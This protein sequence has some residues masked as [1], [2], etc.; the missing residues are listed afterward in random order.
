M[1]WAPLSLD[2]VLAQA[3]ATPWLTWR[4][5]V[6]Q[7]SQIQIQIQIQIQALSTGTSALPN[8]HL[9]M[10]HAHI[11]STTQDLLSTDDNEQT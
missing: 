9:K 5:G 8:K 11:N 4:T 1:E 10:D 7:R 6:T 3:S 2:W